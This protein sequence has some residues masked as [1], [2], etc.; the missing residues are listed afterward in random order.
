MLV[1]SWFVLLQAVRDGLTFLLTPDGFLPSQ[2]AV[3]TGVEALLRTPFLG[4]WE[5]L[6]HL[7]V[8]CSTQQKQQLR[9][10]ITSG[11]SA[12][13]FRGERDVQPRLFRTQH[14]RHKHMEEICAKKYQRETGYFKH[15]KPQAGSV[16][17]YKERQPVWR[18]GWVI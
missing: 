16:L 14:A 6:T 11:M 18:G 4:I 5:Y 13:C 1:K 15:F 9:R 12:M 3:I 7:T 10:K 17:A 8:L 2:R